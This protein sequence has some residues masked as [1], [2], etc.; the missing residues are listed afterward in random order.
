MQVKVAQ[1]GSGRDGN[2]ASIT[3]NPHNVSA[4]AP[5]AP[6]PITVNVHVAMHGS[7]MS[8]ADGKPEANLR[9]DMA[10]RAV[11]Q[12]QSHCAADHGTGNP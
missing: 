7:C 12:R 11:G 2:A 4:P 3:V 9:H 1:I 5:T 8:P 6:T 10:E